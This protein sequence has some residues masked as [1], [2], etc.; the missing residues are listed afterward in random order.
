MQLRLAHDARQ[1]Q[2]QPVVVG[3]RVV[4]ALTVADDHAEDRAQLQQLVPVAVVAGQARSVQAQHQ[5]GLAQADLG[6]QALEAVALGACGARLAQVVVDHR[7]PLARPA[8]PGGP[9]GQAVLQLRALLVLADLARR[10]LAHVDVGELGAMGRG[11]P[12]GRL[13]QRGQHGLPPRPGRVAAGRRFAVPVVSA[14]RGAAW[15]MAAGDGGGPLPVAGWV[16][17][18]VAG[19]VDGPDWG[20]SAWKAS[21]LEAANMLRMCRA[22]GSS[23]RAEMR[24]S[25]ACG[26]CGCSRSVA[27]RRSS[28]RRPSGKATA[29]KA[30][31]RLQASDNSL[32]SR[33][34]RG[35]CGSVT[36]TLETTRS[37]SGADRSVR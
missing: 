1:A 35:W 12:L 13:I 10:G 32:S 22:S 24:G 29:M 31:P 6:D 2:E 7:D 26:A 17:L 5:P 28:R 30:G 21:L 3:A 11:D 33:P 14:P 19:G 34:N 15:P 27:A 20:W 37:K 23:A 8:K 9:V 36:V 4:Q 25:A 16:E 18:P